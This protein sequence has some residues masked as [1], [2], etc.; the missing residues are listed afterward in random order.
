MRR[1]GKSPDKLAAIKGIGYRIFISE[2]LVTFSLL[3]ARRFH[4]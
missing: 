3:T 1:L 4:T 2:N